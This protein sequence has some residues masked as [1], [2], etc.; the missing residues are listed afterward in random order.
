MVSTVPNPRIETSDVG[1]VSCS[2]LGL[3]ELHIIDGQT[4][5]LAATDVMTANVRAQQVAS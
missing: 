1:L 2:R 3:D 5:S 4:I